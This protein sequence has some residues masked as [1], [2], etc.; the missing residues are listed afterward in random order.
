MSTTFVLESTFLAMVGGAIGCLI[1]LELLLLHEPGLPAIRL[2]SRISRIPAFLQWLT[3]ID[4]LHYFLVVLRGTLLKGV[5][6][7]V[8]WP[9]PAPTPNLDGCTGHRDTHYSVGG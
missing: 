1:R 7:A 2:R 4:P 3:Y 5:A 9:P 8:R 6:L